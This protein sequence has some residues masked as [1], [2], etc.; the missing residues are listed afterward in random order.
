MQSKCISSISDENLASELK[1][2]TSTMFTLGFEDL[3]PWSN[4]KMSH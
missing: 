1:Y 2:A 3:V 4:V